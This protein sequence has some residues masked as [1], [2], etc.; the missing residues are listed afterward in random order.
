MDNAKLGTVDFQLEDDDASPV[1][2]RTC[3]AKEKHALVF[4]MGTSDAE[5]HNSDDGM[6]AFSAGPALFCL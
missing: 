5:V 1:I 2:F 6:D 4:Q 3:P